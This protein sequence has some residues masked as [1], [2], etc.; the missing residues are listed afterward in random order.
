MP[1]I[2]QEM[3]TGFRNSS[4]QLSVAAQVAGYEY[5]VEGKDPDPLLV[6]RDGDHYVVVKQWRAPP[7]LTELREAV[8]EVSPA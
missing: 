2:L 4:G 5:W 8:G 7:S 6:L 1:K 3:P